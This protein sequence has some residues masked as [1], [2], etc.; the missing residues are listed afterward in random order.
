MMSVI[1]SNRITLGI[2]QRIRRRDSGGVFMTAIERKCFKSAR[3]TRA[4]LFDPRI[5]YDPSSHR[6]FASAMEQVGGDSTHHTDF[7]NNDVILAM[8]TDDV[9]HCNRC[10]RPHEDKS[11]WKRH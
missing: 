9:Q 3:A 7:V 1:E 10:G 5:L 2:H 8:S 4:L 11:R 6:W